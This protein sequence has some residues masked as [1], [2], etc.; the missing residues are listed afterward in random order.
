MAKPA[1]RT[2][3]IEV[4]RTGGFAG[5]SRE[6]RV[7]AQDDDCDDWM[8]LIEACPWHRVPPPDQL[9]RDRF[10]WRIEVDGPGLHRRATLADGGLDGPWR[11]LVERVQDA[12]TP[13]A[14]S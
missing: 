4:V 12:A 13:A 14:P 3:E 10:V 2:V 1:D 5:I 11:S 8:P 9:S 6:W 7:E